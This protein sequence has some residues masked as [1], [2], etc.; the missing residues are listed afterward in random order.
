M[1]KPVAIIS[2]TLAA[3]CS[4][5]LAGCGG[6]NGGGRQMAS[7][8]SNWYTITSYKDIQPTFTEGNKGN[9]GNDLF[10]SEKITYNVDFAAPEEGKGNATYSVYYSQ[11]TYT[12]LF[13]GVNFNVGELTCDEYKSGYPEKVHAYYYRTELDI[14]S[15]IFTLKKDG[16]TYIFEK[17]LLITE[18]Y[19]MPVGDFL[20]PLYS[21]Q[22]VKSTTP[23]NFQVSALTEGN[24]YKT[25]NRVYECFYS[26]DGSSV[27]TVTTDLIKNGEKTEKTDNGLSGSAFTLFDVSS[28]NIAARAVNLYASTALSQN[29]S[30]VSPE[31]GVR[32]FTLRGSDAP[33]GDDAARAVYAEKLKAQNLYK[34]S[35]SGLK[36]VAVNM[37]YGGRLT[38]VSQTF[39]FAAVENKV[40]N[41]GR[42]TM[43]KMSTPLP[44]GLGTLN[45]TLNEIES[46]LWNGK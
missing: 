6:C 7:L 20:R 13:Q 34:D 30:I 11:G 32:D 14:P 31:N 24:A 43:L 41:T 37:I 28:L 22:T 10:S 45:Y 23:A 18:C 1:K 46:T 44:Y 25:V 16:S 21:K 8:S 15:G 26:Y 4:V 38:G 3:V 27:K 39:W 42:A 5:G 19:F 40:N 17:D 33:V 12:T 9:D 29:V 35:E 36:T 2:V